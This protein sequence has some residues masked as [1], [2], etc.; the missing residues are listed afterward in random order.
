M[1]GVGTIPFLGA[2]W[3]PNVFMLGGEVDDTAIDHLRRNGRVVRRSDTGPARAS[4]A[5][6]AC[7]WDAQCLPLRDGVVD[8]MVV[9]M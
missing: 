6:A 9:D 5:A 2:N 7:A 4:G 1:C 8:A 3:F